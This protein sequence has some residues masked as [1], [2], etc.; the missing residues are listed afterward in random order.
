VHQ[1][2]AGEVR[3]RDQGERCRLSGWEH[4]ADLRSREGPKC[5]LARSDGR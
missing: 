3:L 1:W 2:L 5:H 4:G